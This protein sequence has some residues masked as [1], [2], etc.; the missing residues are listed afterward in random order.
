M[1]ACSMVEQNMFDLYE[2]QGKVIQTKLQQLFSTLERIDKLK[3]EL[4]QVRKALG[5]IYQDVSH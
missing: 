3:S 1:K 5:L 2:T 4:Q